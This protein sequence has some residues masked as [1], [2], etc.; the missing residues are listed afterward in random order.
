MI[1]VD[2]YP[3]PRVVRIEPASQCNLA[4]SHCPTGTVDM[5]RG[6]MSASTFARIR[7][8]LQKHRDEIKVV[9]LYHGGE[10]LLNKMFFDWIREIKSINSQF[11]VKTV[12]NGMALTEAMAKKLLNTPID[13]IEFSL[14]GESGDESQLIREKSSTAKIVGNIKYLLSLKAAQGVA[15]PEIF[16][17]TTQFLRSRFDNPEVKIPEWL[18]ETFP[19]GVAGFKGALAMQWP[20]MGRVTKYEVVKAA[21]VD[22]DACDHVINTITIRA[23]GTVVPCCYDLTSKLPMG[24]VNED[25]LEE[26]WNSDR[27]LML[28][29]S[30]REKKYISICANCAVVRPGNYLIPKWMPVFPA[31]A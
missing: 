8:A 18:H 27:Y 24:N 5:E 7:A 29:R 13:A 26:I 16:I 22:R 1:Q 12:S 11:F 25:E 28:R 14:D 20:H 31:T 3:F 19:E 15:K 21:G 9:V 10:P 6:V 4:C 2:S 17:A 23:D 30:I